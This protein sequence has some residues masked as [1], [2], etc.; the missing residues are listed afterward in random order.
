MEHNSL[1]PNF[2]YKM[3]QSGHYL[4]KI[5]LKWPAFQRATTIKC[6]F[7]QRTSVIICQ[8]D[9]CHK[10]SFLAGI[11]LHVCHR[12]NNPVK[13]SLTYASPVEIVSLFCEEVKWISEVFSFILIPACFVLYACVLASSL[14]SR[15]VQSRS[16]I[17]HRPLHARRQLDE[18]SPALS[19]VK[20]RRFVHFAWCTN[21]MYW[22]GLMRMV[23]KSY[24]LHKPVNCLFFYARSVIMRMC[25]QSVV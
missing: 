14:T 3:P 19:T 22:E 17:L 11:C 21:H 16:S 20:T 1:V 15:S 18:T 7:L 2:F 25:L 9:S 23:Y 13:F 10:M 6:V 8:Q 24:K 5:L 12:N 4:L